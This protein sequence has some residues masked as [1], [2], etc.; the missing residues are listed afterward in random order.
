MVYENKNFCY[1]DIRKVQL[2][3]EY[4]RLFC[5]ATENE[6]KLPIGHS[7]KYAAQDDVP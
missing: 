5:H 3:T 4:C 1:Q 2:R 6:S 7:E